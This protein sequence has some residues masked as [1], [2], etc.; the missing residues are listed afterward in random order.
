MNAAV[1]DI[2][3]RM[4]NGEYGRPLFI[5]GHYL[6]ES[7][8]KSTDYSKRLVPET[9]RARALAD[10][11][12]H[13]AD[14]V[15][16]VMCQPIKSVMADMHTHYPYRIDPNTGDE[17]EIRSDDTTTVLFRLLAGTPGMQL[18]SKVSSGHKNDLFFAVAT[19]ECEVGWYQEQSDRI[20]ISK[21]EIGNTEIYIDSKYTSATVSQ[22]I[23]LPPGHVMGWSDALRNSINAYYQSIWSG[24]YLSSKQPYATFK[25]GW[26]TNLFIDACI[27][28]SKEKRWVDIV[29]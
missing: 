11:G 5:R 21:R 29:Y 27:I 4:H 26:Y 10:I 15:G 20:Y 7:H 24:T 19:D 25:D 12:S 17:I 13:L 9:S 3:E 8:C 14:I 28:S 18:V 1:Q 23:S 16:C 22:Y 2:K 6:Q